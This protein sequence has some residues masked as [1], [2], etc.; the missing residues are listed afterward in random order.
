MVKKNCEP[1]PPSEEQPSPNEQ[2]PHRRPKR[3]EV[4]AGL[5]IITLPTLYGAYSCLPDFYPGND[6]L[7]ACSDTELDDGV[8]L[9]HD[10]P[11][12]DYTRTPSDLPFSSQDEAWEHVFRDSGIDVNGYSEGAPALTAT[13]VRISGGETDVL[14]SGVITYSAND[15]EQGHPIILTVVNTEDL[16][17]L[18]P[19][20]IGIITIGSNGSEFH[21]NGGCTMLMPGPYDTSHKHI[22][23]LT[24]AEK[25]EN[26]AY[27]RTSRQ[28][29]LE[30]KNGIITT[31][32][33]DDLLEQ[34]LTVV[35]YGSQGNERKIGKPVVASGFV[36]GYNDAAHTK[37]LL[38]SSE[39]GFDDR[40]GQGSP[41]F[42]QNNPDNP[43][44][45]QLGGLVVQG[46][47][48]SPT[49]EY[50]K[51]VYNV[52]VSYEDI[53]THHLKLITVTDPAITKDLVTNPDVTEKAAQDEAQQSTTS[54]TS[55]S[56]LYASDK[57][58]P[59]WEEPE[60]QAHSIPKYYVD[61]NA[62]SDKQ[63]TRSN[64][65]QL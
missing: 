62:T 23:A 19:D 5:A 6:P 57:P 9:G 49:P 17:N 38:V 33:Q 42:V 8:D 53:D 41:L 11:A 21:P 14:Y 63:L 37:T 25:N 55:R 16:E 45:F 35:N 28:M 43:H 47:I 51:K 7:P 61:P 20:N 50:L 39:D 60:N 10:K 18:T 13:K 48:A 15:S 59:Y 40:T 36:V 12:V 31:I 4:I 26:H 2:Q 30:V 46:S 56:N 3:K 58:R 32:T 44:E 34:P 24:L 1:L 27:R 52:D 29:S 22:V 64:T 65:A 54:N